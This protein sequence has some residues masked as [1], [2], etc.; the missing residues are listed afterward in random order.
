MFGAFVWSGV[1]IGQG[2]FLRDEVV[3]RRFAKF[4]ALSV[5]GA[6][7][8]WLGV[9]LFSAGWLSYT[10]HA[11]S[12]WLELVVLTALQ[13]CVVGCVI[14]LGQ[15]LALRNMTDRC[16]W[17]VVA[18]VAATSLGGSI[19]FGLG[20]L[21]YDNLIPWIWRGSYFPWVAEGLLVIAASTLSAFFFALLTIPAATR[22]VRQLNADKPKP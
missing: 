11:I 18:T 2:R 13:L 3:N 8:S 6:I 9:L 7:L 16:F 19:G 15:W 21:V 20:R 10:P 12:S 22:L 14:G 5:L 1:G 17:W 4:A